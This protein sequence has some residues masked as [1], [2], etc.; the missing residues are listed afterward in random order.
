[1]P[2]MAKWLSGITA[3]QFPPL[4]ADFKLCVVSMP[5][6][7]WSPPK[8]LLVLPPAET[9]P[10]ILMWVG[11]V[12]CAR[13]LKFDVPMPGG[14]V[15]V[16]V[17]LPPICTACV[18]AVWQLIAVA[19]VTTNLIRAAVTSDDAV[20]VWPPAETLYCCGPFFTSNR[21][22]LS[23]TPLLTRMLS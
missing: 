8:M 14:A 18:I 17:P 3:V 6:V 20:Q 12:H 16:A 1:M 7:M 5:P 21:P 9:D 23:P 2:V 13:M 10:Q 22:P 19:V 4:A 11:V 15:H